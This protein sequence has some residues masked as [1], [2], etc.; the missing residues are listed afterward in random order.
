MTGFRL[1]FSICLLMILGLACSNENSNPDKQ[2]PNVLLILTDDQGMGDV[3]IHGN[4]SIETP[5][6][7]QLAREGVRMNFFYVS[8]VCAP[9]RASL[10]TGRY[11]YRTGTTW[12]TR[13]GEAMRSEEVT[14]AEVFKANG[15]AT[16]CFGKWHNGAHFPQNPLGQGFDTF[17]GFSGGQWN[18]YYDPDLESEG[19]K[20][21]FKGYITDILTDAA[22][23]FISKNKDQPFFAY[24]PYNAPHSPFIAPDSL[25]QKYRQKGLSVRNASIYGMI[26]SIDTNIGRLLATLKELELLENTLVIFMT[27]NGPNGDRYTMDLRGRKGAVSDGG[28]RVPCFFYW[29]DQLEGGQI[30]EELTAHIDILPTLVDLLNLDPIST[31][32]LDGISFASLL[33]GGLDS[34]PERNFYTFSVNRNPF[35]G[36]VRNRTHRLTVSGEKEFRLTQWKE[37]PSEKHDLKG[38]SPQLAEAMYHDYLNK[39]EEVTE[40]LDAFLPIPLGYDEAPEVDLPAHEGFSQGGLRYKSSSQGWNNDWWVNWT[41]ELDTMYWNIEVASE[42]SYKAFLKYECQ[43]EY[44]GSYIHLKVGTEEI[45]AQLTEAFIGETFHNRE[46][47]S[48]GRVADDQTWGELALGEIKLSKGSER[49]CLFAS[50]I[51]NGQVAETKGLR[52]EKIIRE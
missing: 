14:L 19:K 40:E 26:E 1:I 49:I 39:Y 31:L 30:I 20:T 36:S 51:S 37:D 21:R 13:N 41:S 7:D 48:R 8:P 2:R 45:S 34:L 46:Q 23:D 5:V 10:L 9:T 33:N 27:D 4:D 17:T 42:T 24:L 6:Q 47:L 43:R 38:Q 16:G 11:H 35:K 28:V 22:V 3:G 12:M 32:P 50:D 44:V 18:R 29:K 52:L 15:Y 25:F